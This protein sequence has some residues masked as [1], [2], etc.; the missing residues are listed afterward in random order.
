MGGR[1]IRVNKEKERE[2]YERAR[3]RKRT[4]EKGE[5]LNGER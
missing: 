5:E 2:E 4:D 3:E 1:E